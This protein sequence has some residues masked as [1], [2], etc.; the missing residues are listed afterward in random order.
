MS[1][2]KALTGVHNYVEFKD[3]T[4]ASR[5][6][7]MVEIREGLDVSNLHVKFSYGNRKTGNLVPSA[8]LIPV[9]D[10]K[11]CE[12][13]KNG[14]YAV[15]NI[16]CYDASR[17]NLANNSAIARKDPEKFFREVDGEMKKNCWF[18][19]FVSGDILSG[20]FFDAM[21]EVSKR[22]PHCQVLAFTKQF[23]IVNQWIDYNGE[24]PSNLHIIFSE[25][26]GLD[27]PNP[28]SLPTSRPVWKGEHV[29]SGIWCGGDCSACA[30]KDDGCWALK[31]GE[32]V[33]FEAH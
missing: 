12:L 15:R 1:S 13:C 6:K 20:A 28:H 7:K 32:R 8:S 16:A 2:H 26:R 19:F 5:V 18:R 33:L 3:E 4:I 10:C 31:P 9:A 21:V 14:C 22:N 25:W 29:P 24:L 23:R 27:V 30:V 17:K 11:S